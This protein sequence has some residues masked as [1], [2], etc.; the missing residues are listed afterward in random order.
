MAR[1]D[2]LTGLPNRA[3]LDD[4]LEQALARAKRSGRSI[5]V[6]LADLDRFKAI[7]DTYGHPVGDQ[8]LKAISSR[9]TDCL[10]SA[11]TLARVGGDEFVIILEELQDHSD[12]SGVADKLIAAAC[13]AVDLPQ[14]RMQVGVC[15]G[16]AFSPLHGGDSRSLIR[17][18]DDAMYAAKAAGGN[19]WRTA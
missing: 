8:M 6:M 9:M 10:R 16:I 19:C 5:A 2:P 3:L 4:R 1:H 14:G 17:H 18:A 13:R 12:A 7:N 11:D 15:I